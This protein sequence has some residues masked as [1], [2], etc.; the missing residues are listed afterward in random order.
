MSQH[1]KLIPNLC[2]TKSTSPSHQQ[3]G[4]AENK[5]KKGKCSK[6]GKGNCKETKNSKSGTAQ[7]L[8]ALSFKSMTL[9]ML[10]LSNMIHIA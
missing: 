6:N 3:L 2:N 8:R 4:S 5:N 9:K 1:I 7:N 10:Q